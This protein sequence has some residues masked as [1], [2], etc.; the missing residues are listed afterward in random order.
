[1]IANDVYDIT[2][3]YYKKLILIIIAT[4]KTKASKNAKRSC[5][6]CHTVEMFLF[7]ITDGMFRDA[8]CFDLLFIYRWRRC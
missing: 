1:M 3:F 4:Y 5:L 7:L 2:T 6:L 8:I